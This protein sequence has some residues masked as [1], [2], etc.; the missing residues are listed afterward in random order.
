MYI[1]RRDQCGYAGI[2]ANLHT[3][4]YSRGRKGYDCLGIAR[5][6]PQVDEAVIQ[7][8][9]VVVKGRSVISRDLR[10]AQ[11]AYVRQ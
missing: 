1:Q 6:Q 3:V 2:K 10:T 9:T 4:E 5:Q 7:R 8:N 11:Q